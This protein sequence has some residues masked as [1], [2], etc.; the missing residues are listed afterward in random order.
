AQPGSEQPPPPQPGWG[1]Q[2]PPQPGWGQQPPPQPGWG[3]QPTWG[4]PPP[5]PGWAPPPQAPKPGIVPLR[6]LGVGDLLEGALSFIRSDPR[7]IL[8]LAAVLA[9]GVG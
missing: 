5:G 6:A 7:T 9:V 8:G 3:Q 4:Q 1:Q 2:P